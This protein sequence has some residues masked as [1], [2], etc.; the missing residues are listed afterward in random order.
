MIS[1]STNTEEK[2]RHGIVTE[3][4]YYLDVQRQFD[5]ALQRGKSLPTVA[6]SVERITIDI[7]NTRKRAFGGVLP[8]DETEQPAAPNSER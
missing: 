7:R 4:S 5:L 6:R 2:H 3:P 8:Q 1:T